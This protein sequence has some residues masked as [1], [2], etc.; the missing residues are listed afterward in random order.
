MGSHPLNLALRF[1]LELV[2]WGGVGLWGWGITTGPRRY[3]LAIG[4]PLL[5]M[6]LWG[7]FAVPGDPSRSGSAPIP[8]PGALRLLL[9][10]AIFA[11]GVWALWASGYPQWSMGFAVVVL[12]HYLISYDR[13]AWLLAQGHSQ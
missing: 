2:A 11:V 3:L 9:E 6:A 10:L 1:L 13:I 12:L 7:V 5:L 8:V 4:L